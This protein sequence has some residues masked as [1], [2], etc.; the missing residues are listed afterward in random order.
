[1]EL[2]PKISW[3]SEPLN[4]YERVDGKHG[5]HPSSQKKNIILKF[6]AHTSVFSTKINKPYSTEHIFFFHFPKM[7]CDRLF[8]VVDNNVLH[9]KQWHDGGGKLCRKTNKCV[10]LICRST[11]WIIFFFFFRTEKFICSIRFYWCEVIYFNISCAMVAIDENFAFFC[12]KWYI[13]CVSHCH[14]GP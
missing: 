9:S 14:I 12:M 7:S 8:S 2:A 3:I 6:G 1:M 4:N 5:S 13:L 11:K 10:R